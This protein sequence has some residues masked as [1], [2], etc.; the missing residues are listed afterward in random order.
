[1]SKVVRPEGWND[2]KNP[3]AHQTARYAGKGPR[4]R[5]QLESGSRAN[6]SKDNCGVRSHFTMG[7]RPSGT[8]YCPII[9]LGDFYGML[10]TSIHNPY[11]QFTMYFIQKGAKGCGLMHKIFTIL[12]GQKRRKFNRNI[13]RS[14]QVSNVFAKKRW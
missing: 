1:M 14:A 7:F 10:F 8:P 13:S 2:W 3:G 6:K 11:R 12:M 5:G 4:R 9:K